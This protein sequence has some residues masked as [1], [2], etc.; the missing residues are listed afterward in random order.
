MKWSFLA[1][2]DKPRYLCVNADEGEPG[3]YKDRSSWRTIPTSSSRAASSR[4]TRSTARPATSTCA[5]SSTRPRPRLE[6]AIAE[7]YAAGYL[8]KN[9]L[10]LGIDLDIVRAQR[11]GLL[12]VRRGDGAPGEPRGQARAAAASSRRSRRCRGLYDCPTAVNNVETICCVPLILER[13]RGVVRRP[14]ASRRTAGPSSTA[15]A[16]T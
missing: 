15:S 12:R 7:A 16:A 9:I 3:T 5:A 1:K 4:P 10:G 2:N 11:R 6:K 8:G 13:G 14:T